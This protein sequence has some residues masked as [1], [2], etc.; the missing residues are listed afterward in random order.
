MVG[1]PMK[2]RGIRH[3]LLSLVYSIVVCQGIVDNEMIKTTTDTMLVISASVLILLAK[4]K[5]LSLLTVLSLFVTLIF[6]F[7]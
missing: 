6:L 5:S 3:S 1:T 4:T 2:S 7:L